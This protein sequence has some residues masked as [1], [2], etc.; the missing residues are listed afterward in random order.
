[1]SSLEGDRRYGNLA[2]AMRFA[3]RRCHTL[4]QLAVPGIVESF[5][6]RT[7]RAVVRGALNVVTTNG[8]ELQR[9]SLVNVPVV[10]P[11]GGGYTLSFQLAVGDP[12]LLVYSMRGLDQWKQTHAEATPDE[13]VFFDESD[14][15]AIPGF[16]QAAATELPSQQRPVWEALAPPLRG[17]GA[18][19]YVP[20]APGAFTLNGYSFTNAGVAPLGRSVDDVQQRHASFLYEAT[21]PE[22]PFEPNDQITFYSEDGTQLG[23]VVWGLDHSATQRLRRGDIIVYRVRFQRR[24]LSIYPTNTIV[25]A[26]LEANVFYEASLGTADSFIAVGPNGVEASSDITSRSLTLLNDA[27][28][29]GG[30]VFTCASDGS[31]DRAARTT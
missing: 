12:V 6:P 27:A 10:W 5:D 4:H 14:A 25:R 17:G 9:A 28:P 8:T 16:G 18:A 22:Y 26:V 31:L 24:S 3:H 13:G 29:G 1:M 2:S 15:I 21:G 7:R 19:E 30:S 20:A 23:Q 11:S